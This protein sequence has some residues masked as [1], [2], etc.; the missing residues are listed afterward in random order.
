M[1]NQN[2]NIDINPITDF[3]IELNE[4][5]PQGAQGERGPAGPTGNGISSIVKSSTSGLTDTYTINYTN[6]SHYDYD[7]KNGNGIVS[8]EKT[9]TSGLVDTYT[10]TMDNGDEETFTVTNGQN[11]ID[12][13]DGISP[14]A[15][16]TQTPT[17]ATI[18]ITDSVGTTTVD[19]LNGENGYSPTASVVQTTIGAT[20]TVTDKSGTTTANIFNGNDGTDGR[21]AEITGATASIGTNSGTPTVS[22]AALGNN[23]SRSFAFAFDGLKGDAATVDVGTTTTGEPGTDASVVNSGTDS[24]AVLDFT[25]P[26]GEP[27]FS[28]T[29]SV[30]KTGS[31]STITITD[32]NGTTSAQ[33]YD[34]TLPSEAIKAY[35]DAG[36]LMT[37]EKGLSDVKEYAHST[38]DESKFTKVGT[39]TIT[40]DGIASGFSDS[41]YFK[42]GIYDWSKPFKIKVFATPTYISHTN[43]ILLSFDNNDVNGLNNAFRI[44]WNAERTAFYISWDIDSQY[45]LVSTSNLP[46]SQIYLELIY[47]GADRYTVKYKENIEDNWN[48]QNSL[49]T[50]K[51]LAHTKSLIIGD[52]IYRAW[53]GSIDLKQ[54]SITVDGVPVFSGNKTGI[55]TI[56]PDDYTV[57]GSPIISA[58]GIASGFS[59]S[60]YISLISSFNS[61]SKIDI[62]IKNI[63][64]QTP[65]SSYPKNYVLFLGTTNAEFPKIGWHKDGRYLGLYNGSFWDFDNNNFR[66][67]YGSSYDFRLTWDGAEYKLY[68]KLSNDSSYTLAASFQ[69]STNYL[70]SNIWIGRNDTTIFEYF[71]GSIDLNAF[72]IY[73][74]GDLVYQPCLK[75]PYTES[76][77]GSKVVDSLYRDRVSDMYEQ[78]G[79]APYYTLSDSD[80]TLPQGELYGL[81]GNQTLRS[82]NISTTISTIN[83][84]NRVYLYSD[85]TQ[86][87]TGSCTANTPVTLNT[88]FVNANYMLSV[89]YSAKTATGFTPTQSGDWFAL[90]EGVL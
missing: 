34:G 85:R 19:I 84:S 18:T 82:S 42:C 46:Y 1:G 66:I 73:V 36:E 54:F 40:S 4:Q 38:F 90:G 57:V 2:V 87:L 12:G 47:N 83:S 48:T 29:A 9:D 14:I 86:I 26:K 75:I 72:K 58:D 31:T 13:E 49:T 27:G 3:T 63:I 52:G 43:Q 80:F 60:N 5:G 35:E 53:D 69:S 78:F 7:V 68:G 30:T 21:S 74:D 33:V 59:D 45:G 25:I 37:D 77:T 8:I 11:G 81:M 89:P 24:N 22:V 32:K 88:P 28:P 15:N 55:D 51:V 71:V 79:Y 64:P 67:T 41:K 76:K 70:N 20:V 44:V 6:G 61:S 65:N 39:P 16:V 10:I 50:N 56:K 17:G 62:I 23:Y